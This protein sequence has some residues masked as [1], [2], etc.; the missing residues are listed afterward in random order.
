LK[1]NSEITAPEVRLILSTGEA[2]GILKI[3]EA[4]KLAQEVRLDLVE[5]SPKEVPPV[6]KLLNFGKYRY[7]QQK[8]RNESKKKQKVVDIKE[9]QLRP[10]I[11]KHDLEVKI[12]AA[13]RFL[14]NGDKVKFTMR[15]RGREI[16]HQ[17]LGL[18]VLNKIIATLETLGKLESAPKLEGKQYMMLIAPLGPFKT[19]KEK[20]NIQKNT[21]AP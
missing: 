5:V 11:D 6:C 13:E 19:T 9:I 2:A 10:A 8:K 14:K 16:N 7:E 15:F 12:K 3:S 20:A 4:L 18:D 21:E 17:S 1:V